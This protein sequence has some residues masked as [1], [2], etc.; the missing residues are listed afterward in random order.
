[1]RKLLYTQPRTELADIQPGSSL[2]T[3]SGGDGTGKY[4]YTVDGGR[5]DSNGDNGATEGNPDDID[6]KRN[7]FETWDW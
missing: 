7:S 4:N 5:S 6:A 1:M 3:G 2:A